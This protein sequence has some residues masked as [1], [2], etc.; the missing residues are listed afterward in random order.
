M[1]ALLFY[2]THPDIILPEFATTQSACFD[3]AFQVNGK[4]V[5]NGYNHNNKAFERPYRNGVEIYIG[6]RERV[7]VPTGLILDI[8]KGFSVRVHPRSGTSLKQGLM[9]AN[10]EGV[11]DSDYTQELF[12]LM[13]NVTDVGQLIPN[14]T[15]LA[16]AEM[17]P[18]V[19]YSLSEAFEPPQKKTNR[20]GGLG[21]TGTKLNATE[22][23]GQENKS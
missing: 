17:V 13:Y 1:T 6:P 20:V 12:L 21:S 15:R 23:T 4:H 18:Q 11:I 3:L 16:Q 8:P 14:G 9:L 19:K 10:C 7:L 5:Y 2:K 22:V